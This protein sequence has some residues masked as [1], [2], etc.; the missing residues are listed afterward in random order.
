LVVDKYAQDLNLPFNKWW[1]IELICNETH[2]AEELQ[3]NNT[4]GESC[5]DFGEFDASH[6]Y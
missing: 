4:G 2:P 5:D 6:T 1:E 3:D